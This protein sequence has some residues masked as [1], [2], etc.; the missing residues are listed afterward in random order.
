MKKQQVFVIGG[1]TAS[2]KSSLAIRLAQRLN[3]EIVNGDSIQIYQDLRILSA[4]PSVEDEALVPHYLFGYVDA[5]TTPSITDWL[6]K[7]ADIIPQ[8][9]HP[10]VVG[11]TGMYLDALINGISP[12]P[13]VLPEIR[14][15]VREMPIEAVKKEVKDC[16]F[17]D[18]Q[19]LRRALEVQKSTGHTLLYFQKLKKIKYINADFI[20]IQVMPKRE[21]VYQNCEDRLKL[22]LQMGAIQEVKNLMKKKPTGGVLK[23]IGVKQIFE[24]IQGDIDR[25]Q[26][27][28][29]IVTATRQYAKRQMTWFRHHGN[30]KLIVADPKS[31]NLDKITK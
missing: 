12:I 20:E 2:G 24:Y 29:Q 9:K 3:G 30:S 18:P 23:A 16:P 4:R 5:W 27:E 28:E 14:Q 7:V 6:Q 10:I 1:P 19:R 13:D 11:G 22:M 31:E 25:N 26:L 21:V 8:L 15:Q 17:V